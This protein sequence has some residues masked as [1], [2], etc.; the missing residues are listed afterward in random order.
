MTL[1]EKLAAIR[2]ASRARIPSE[3]RDVMERGSGRPGSC[4]SG[5]ARQRP[6]S[7]FPTTPAIPSD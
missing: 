3:L 4:W 7:P 2:E 1:E 5:R 6:T